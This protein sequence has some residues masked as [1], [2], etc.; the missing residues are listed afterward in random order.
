MDDPHGLKDTP[1]TQDTNKTSAEESTN[2]GLTKRRWPLYALG[3]A[4]L[5]AAI[6]GAI[7]WWLTRNQISTDD[8]YTDGRAVMIA[9]HVSGYVTQ[10]AVT[11]N[12]FVHQ[13][14]LLL[15]IDPRDYTAARDQAEGALTVA[16]AQLAAAR[17]ALD[18]ARIDYPAQKEAADAAVSSAQAV[19]NRAQEDNRRQ[20]A[21]AAA[22][23]TQQ[24]RDT[25]SAAVQ[26]AQAGLR[27]AQ[28][29][30]EQASQVALDISQAEAQVRQLEGQAEQARARLDQANLNL[31]WTRVTAPADGWIT[32]RNVERG[33]LVQSATPLLALVEPQT[34]ITANFKEGQ[35][36]RMRPGQPVS[37]AVDAYPGLKLKGH[38][39]SVQMGSGARF[40]AFP[41]E[42]AT[43]N[44]VKIVRRVPVKI[45]IDSGLTNGPLPLG[46]SV[47]PTVDVQ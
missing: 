7:W 42:N 6:A 38:I 35:L 37:I 10:L 27:Q 46:I 34:W 24:Q 13:G 18:K 33:N 21:V 22:A 36:D 26:Q 14:D 9:P 15:Q 4:I 3:A 28:A 39:D 17:A 44:Y 43:G 23:T 19:L 29:Q 8:A 47:V 2:Q 11:D 30:A 16:Q 5:L 32:R 20:L 41:A 25:A 1:R 40:S 12:Q 31:G 45:I